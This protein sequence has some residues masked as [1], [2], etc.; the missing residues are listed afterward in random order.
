MIML[1]CHVELGY[2]HWESIVSFI[3]LSQQGEPLKVTSIG[4]VDLNIRVVVIC[5]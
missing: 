4:T 2:V 1:I 3:I 5:V